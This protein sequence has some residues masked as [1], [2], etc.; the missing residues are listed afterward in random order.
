MRMRWSVALML[1]GITSALGCSSSSNKANNTSQPQTRDERADPNTNPNVDAGDSDAGPDVNVNANCPAW[2]T[3]KLAPIVGPF[4]FGDG[5]LCHIV[6]NKSAH[7]FYDWNDTHVTQMRVVTT[8][9][10]TVYAY[11]PNNDALL[12]SATLS[13]TKGTTTTSYAY[14]SDATT[15]TTTDTKGNVTTVVYTL[16]PQGYPLQTTIAPPPTDSPVRFVH[17][18]ADCQLKRRVAY[19]A[20]GSVNDDYTADYIYDDQG[21]I[22]ERS[23]PKD[24]ELFVYQAADGTCPPP[25][26]Q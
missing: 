15:W 24:D 18:Y 9:E 17:E 3:E 2:P 26:T 23:A 1:V 10:T 5:R 16:D 11:D 25:P 12:T 8:S 4:F 13:N 21:R 6:I 22:S 19:N 14:K 20:D 7:Q